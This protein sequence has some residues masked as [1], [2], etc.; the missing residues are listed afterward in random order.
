M[1]NQV[2][3]SIVAVA[4]C[5]ACST[6][7]SDAGAVTS[8]AH[9]TY[10]DLRFQPSSERELVVA[11]TRDIEWNNSSSMHGILHTELELRWRFGRG[12]KGPEAKAA[13]AS[14][15][16][17]GEGVKNDE[18]WEHDVIWN[19]RRGY[20]AGRDSRAAKTWIDKELA[21]GVTFV[22]DQRGAVQPGAC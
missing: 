3:F 17:R 8:E 7:G 21:E 14:V 9:Q 2:L 19:R 1:R 4:A 11:Y 5:T 20:L 12:E 22:I 10:Y 18:A 6:P 13:F 15:V 16:Y